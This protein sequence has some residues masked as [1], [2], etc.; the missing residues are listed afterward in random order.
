VKGQVFNFNIHLLCF[1]LLE[2]CVVTKSSPV[3]LTVFYFDMKLFYQTTTILFPHEENKY[4]SVA[5]SIP[6]SYSRGP[7]FGSHPGDQLS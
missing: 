6:T 2:P 1:T 4:H 5:S 7:I 3:D